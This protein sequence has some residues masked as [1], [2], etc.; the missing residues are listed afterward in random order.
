TNNQKPRDPQWTAINPKT[1]KKEPIDLG[2]IMCFDETSGKFLY[3]TVYKKLP[4]GLVVDWP[5]E[6]ICSSPAVDGDRMYYVSNRCELVCSG[7]DG[8]IHWKLDM[9]GQ[10]G[11]F[12]HNL[13]ACSPLVIGDKLFLVTAN[14]V[15]EDHINV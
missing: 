13:A 9:I 14:G 7:L 1:N 2:V 8:T 3:Q 10:L 6:G 11:V 12:P 15:D 5:K 4:Q